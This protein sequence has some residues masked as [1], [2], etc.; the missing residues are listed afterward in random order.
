VIHITSCRLKSTASVKCSIYMCTLH[1]FNIIPPFRTI[2]GCIQYTRY[3]HN[4]MAGLRVNDG[5]VVSTLITYLD[6]FLFIVCRTD[7]I[8]PSLVPPPHR[9]ISHFRLQYAIIR[10][11]ATLQQGPI[12]GSLFNDYYDN[13]VII[14]YKVKF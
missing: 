6:E 5:V 9:L 14:L 11:S 10:L 7:I 13:V 12:G 4:N 8:T 1:T 3:T 2:A